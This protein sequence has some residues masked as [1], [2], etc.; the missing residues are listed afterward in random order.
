MLAQFALL[1]L[2][3]RMLGLT[4]QSKKST[5]GFAAL[6]GRGEQVLGLTEQSKMAGEATFYPGKRIQRAAGTGRG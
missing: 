1:G 2:A 5:C 6:L 4:E 3:E